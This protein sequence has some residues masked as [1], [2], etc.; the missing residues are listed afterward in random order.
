M[1][2]L[3]LTTQLY[4]LPSGR[5]LHKEEDS[6]TWGVDPDIEARIV[7]KERIKLYDLQ[8]RNDILKGK[9][10]EALTDDEIDQVTHYR[11][12]T[13]PADEDEELP[14]LDVDDAEAQADGDDEED[15]EEELEDFVEREDPNEHP[16]RDPQLE[17]ALLLMRI[18]LESGQA[19]P[20]RPVEMVATPA[21]ETTGG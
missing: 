1:A 6:E 5:C 11:G 7:P 12:S 9:N 8:L 21:G 3:K 15:E 20:P 17:I 18:R 16:E 14:G 13:K 4:Y 19:W 10:Q 2:Y